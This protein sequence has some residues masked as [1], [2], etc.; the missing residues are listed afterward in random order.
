[1]LRVRHRGPSPRVRRNR[2]IATVVVL[3]L[4]AALV[5]GAFFAFAPRGGTPVAEP[6]DT[7]TPTQTP[8]PTPTPTPTFD[9]TQKSIDD[10]SSAWIIV[11]KTR[12]LSPQDYAPTDLTV[13]NIAGGG[14]LR[15]N[16]AA[17]M[18]LLL[19]AYRAE[20]GNDMASM[21]SY[22]SYSRQVDVYA[23]WVSSLGQ[24]GADLTSARP[25]FSEH[26]TGWAMDLAAVPA[27]CSG[28]Q[29]FGKTNQGKW[30]RDHSWEYGFIIRYPEGYTDIT[31]YEYEPWH[32]RYV[33]IAL[34]TEMHE[35]GI[36]TLEEMFGLPAAPDYVG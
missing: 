22:R 1:M 25:G 33:G 20:T 23:G 14:Q 24:E 31:G 15:A 21:S 13:V 32:V 27:N 7:P 10:P 18:E 3:V 29:C 28:D 30:L 4:V 16:A 2:R 8:T 5:V 9:L 35:K 17:Q 6:S 12:P 34:A 26:Q 19:A 36:M 11:N